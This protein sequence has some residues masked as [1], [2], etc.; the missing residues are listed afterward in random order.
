[1]IRKNPTGSYTARLDGFPQRTF[2]TRREALE[3]QEKLRS[4]RR[5]AHAGL[6]IDAGPITYN[7]LVELYLDTL[8]TPGW[9]RCI[10]KHSQRRFGDRQVR[11]ITPDEIASWVKG[12]DKAPSTVTHILTLFRTVLAMGVE[13]HYLES[14]P[15]ASR[16]IRGPG[17]G[18]VEDIKPFESWAEVLKVAQAA[19][20]ITDRY[21]I[22]FVCA[23]GLRPSEWRELRW[24]DLDLKAKT[25]HVRGTKTKGS[26]RIIPLSKNALRPLELM[27][28]PIDRNTLVFRNP[29]GTAINLRW[30]REFYWTHALETAGVEQRPTY[31]MRHTFATLALEAG[32]PIDSVSKLMGHEGIETTLRYYAKWTRPMQDNARAILDQIG[33]SDEGI[34]RQ[35]RVPTRNG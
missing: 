14:S 25:C 3:Y 8:V 6:S 2:P 29:D 13:W 28:R 7:A 11:T 12:L 30:W 16:F 5:R 22:E 24:H 10:L 21:I 31:Q 17:R 32:L 35:G 27:V 19:D 4:E 33:E 9:A 23:T 18:R 1:M 15:A 20:R 34:H 26:N